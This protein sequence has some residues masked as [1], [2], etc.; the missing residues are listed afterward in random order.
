MKNILEKSV[1]RSYK[2]C[3]VSLK[4]FVI[5]LSKLHFI[6]KKNAYNWLVGIYSR[7]TEWIQLN[8]LNSLLGVFLKI[9][10]CL[11]LVLILKAL[12]ERLTLLDIWREGYFMPFWE[13]S[14]KMTETTTERKDSIWLAL[15]W[16]I[17]LRISLKIHL[18]RM[19]KKWSGENC[20]PANVKYRSM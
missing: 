11:T 9:K 13:K 20:T 1:S 3:K 18:L 7:R 16:R 14:I 4:L 2:I 8:H 12:V 5:P 6:S 19:R 17:S 15:W 10:C